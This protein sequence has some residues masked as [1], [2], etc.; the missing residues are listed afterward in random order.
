M[1]GRPRDKRN[2]DMQQVDSTEV[3]NCNTGSCLH[4]L[5][6]ILSSHFLWIFSSLGFWDTLPWTSSSLAGS[7]F[8][9]SSLNDLIESPGFKDHLD[10][11][12]SQVHVSDLPSLWPPG[13]CMQLLLW[14]PF[15]S[16]SPLDTCA[17][18]IYL[19]AWLFPQ[20]TMGAS[21]RQKLRSLYCCIL[22]A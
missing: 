4:S 2:V 16:P 22:S 8:L 17:A 20:T 10:S 11:E 13:S 12:D 21:W 15:P 5:P 1:S 7:P 18:I 6:P 9:V 14:P 19:S 3:D